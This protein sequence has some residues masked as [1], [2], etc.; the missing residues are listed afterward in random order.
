MKASFGRALTCLHAMIMY[1]MFMFMWRN[2]QVKIM[3]P[4][5]QNSRLVWP[6]SWTLEATDFDTLKPSE[7][8]ESL[9]VPITRFFGISSAASIDSYTLP[10]V[11]LSQPTLTTA[12]TMKFSSAVAVLAC[13]GSAQAFVPHALP[14]SARVR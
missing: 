13:V 12:N 6:K 1:D 11:S 3:E 14:T 7:L 10:R 5:S 8:A 2:S 4:S 9:L